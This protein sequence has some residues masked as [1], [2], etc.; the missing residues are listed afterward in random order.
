M[1]DKAE[2]VLE[3]NKIKDLLAQEAVLRWLKRLSEKLCLDRR[4]SHP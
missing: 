3:F 1:N 4:L 2:K